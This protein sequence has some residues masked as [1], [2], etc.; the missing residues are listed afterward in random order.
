MKRLMLAI[1]EYMSDD[2]KKWITQTFIT[3]ESS[4]WDFGLDEAARRAVYAKVDIPY[5]EDG[6]LGSIADQMVARGDDNA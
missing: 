5:D 4:L 6:N 1:G 3:P 2:P